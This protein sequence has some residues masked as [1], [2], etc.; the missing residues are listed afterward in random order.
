MAPHVA[1]A[2]SLMEKSGIGA[3]PTLLTYI[4]RVFENDK[5]TTC[6]Q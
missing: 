2:K 1:A 6:L 4:K 3:K 5:T